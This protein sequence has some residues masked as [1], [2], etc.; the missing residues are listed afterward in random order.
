MR[1][2]HN[3]FYIYLIIIIIIISFARKPRFRMNNNCTKWN[4]Q[5]PKYEDL[6]ILG[7]SKQSVFQ[8]KNEYATNTQNSNNNSNNNNN[9]VSNVEIHLNLP[10]LE[11]LTPPITP[12]PS[13]PNKSIKKDITVVTTSMYTTY[14]CKKTSYKYI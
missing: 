5:F 2:K 3:S 14:F 10:K 4:H 11:S 7:S 12:V 13:L 9:N 1:Y 6:P 8:I